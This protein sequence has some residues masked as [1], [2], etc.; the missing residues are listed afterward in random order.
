MWTELVNKQWN[1]ITYD[2]N[3]KQI[4]QWT[5]YN[6]NLGKPSIDNGMIAYT[7][8]PIMVDQ[9][10]INPSELHLL[11]ILTGQENILPNPSQTPAV[12]TN[13]R[14]PAISNGWLT[15]TMEQEQLIIK[16]GLPIALPPH[17]MLTS[18]IDG[19]TSTASKGNGEDFPSIYQDK[20]N[21]N[22]QIII[23]WAASTDN[24][25]ETTI[26]GANVIDASESQSYN[27]KI[28]IPNVAR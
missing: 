2:L 25:F 6:G 3:T 10:Q 28:Y 17:I 14:N 8:N 20:T 1:L 21:P 13:Y 12:I 27:Y 19:H 15:Y 18:L 5:A 24:T 11:N 16:D 7:K 26:M 23:T 22:N 4:K 9:M